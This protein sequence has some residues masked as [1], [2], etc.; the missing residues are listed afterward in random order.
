MC[1][2]CPTVLCF[3][4]CGFTKT[5]K[6]RTCSI[7]LYYYTSVGTKKEGRRFDSS[8]ALY[9]FSSYYGFSGKKVWTRY[10]F[11]AHT[12]CAQRTQQNWL[13]LFFLSHLEDFHQLKRTKF[14]GEPKKWMEMTIKSCA[15]QKKESRSSLVVWIWYSFSPEPSDWGKAAGCLRPIKPGKIWKVKKELCFVLSDPAQ[16]PDRLQSLRKIRQTHS[17]GF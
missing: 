4:Q 6:G 15:A 13:G 8:G 9:G 2:F 3:D 14:A 17:S 16:S 7:G 12:T 5:K 1:F 11:Q 10:K